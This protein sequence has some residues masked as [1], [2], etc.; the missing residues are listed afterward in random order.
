ML[1]RAILAGRVQRLKYEEQRPPILGVQHVFLFREPLCASAEQICGRTLIEL[2]TARVA[3]VKVLESKTVALGDAKRVNV[4]TDLA[5]GF[6]S[7]HDAG[8]LSCRGGC[9]SKPDWQ[10]CGKRGY[11]RIDSF[12]A[13]AAVSSTVRR[14][15]FSRRRV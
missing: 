15:S 10:I 3:R 12:Y 11:A 2:E 8:F 5:E 1:D 7:Q 13:R 6:F 9:R 4:F 14:C